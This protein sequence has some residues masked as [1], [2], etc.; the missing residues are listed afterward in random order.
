M[1]GRQDYILSEHGHYQADVLASFLKQT[2]FAEYPPSRLYCSPLQRARQTAEAVR[3]H[4][5]A[6]AY[7][8]HSA[9]LEVDS[10]IFSG[11]TWAEAQAQYPEIC[12]RFRAARDWGA[13]PEGESKQSLWER[14]ESLL[15]ELQQ[16]H[17]ADELIVLMTHGGLIR[18]ALSVLMGIKSEA[19]LFLCIDNTSLSLAG[20]QG[21][22]RYVRYINN[23]RHLNS[24]DFKPDYIP[25]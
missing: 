24:C 23:T 18:A 25:H 20:I 12:R 6:L 14:A 17:Q 10:G 1:Q 9:L 21:Q 11:L 19:E 13:V 3:Q 15:N 8:E 4:L 16:R 7:E 5:P 22:R 2:L